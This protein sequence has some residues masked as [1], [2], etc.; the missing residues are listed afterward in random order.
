MPDHTI[1]HTSFLHQWEFKIPKDFAPAK[2]LC[3]TPI[4]DITLFFA[5]VAK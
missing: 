3:F 1:N 5:D 4:G 2:N